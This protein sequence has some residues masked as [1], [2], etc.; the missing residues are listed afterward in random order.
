[1]GS[2]P[3]AS[4]EAWINTFYHRIPLFEP[5]LASVSVGFRRV[6]NRSSTSC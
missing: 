6:D 5:D 3:V 4:I 1:M 2:P